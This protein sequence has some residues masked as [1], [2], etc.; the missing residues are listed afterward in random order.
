MKKIVLLLAL[1]SALG[2]NAQTDGLSYQAIIIDPNVQE[3]PGVNATGNILPNADVTLRFTI[4]DA[5]GGE[6]Y[7]ETQDTRTDKYGMVNL[8]IGQ[9][10]AL[11]GNNFT[12]IFW[13]GTRKDLQ[14]EVKLNG[15]F[16]DL[17]KNKLTFVPYAYHRDIIATGYFAL[18]GPATLGDS[19][20]VEGTT[21]LNNSLSVNNE[22]PTNL[23]GTL[24]VDGQTDLNNTVNI[25]NGSPLNA[26]GALNVVGDSQLDSDLTVDGITN[27][28]NDLN[29]NNNRA[30]VL[31]G[32]LRVDGQTDLNGDVNI[33]NGSGLD[34]S[35]PLNVGG[36]TT[37]GDDLIV[38]GTTNLNN[39]LDVNN[40][41]PSRLTGTLNVE[42]ET[43]LENSLTVEG[44]TSL[45]SSFNVNNQSPSIL[46]GSLTVDLET[47]LNSSLSVNNE[48]PTFL[49]GPLNVD[50]PIGLNNN[51]TVNGITN[52]NGSLFVNN[53]APTNL[54]GSLFVGGPA[55][56]DS[57][58]IVNGET[59]LNQGLTVANASETLLTGELFVDGETFLNNT[60][61][62]LN[63]SPTN[64]TGDLNVDGITTLNNSL[65]VANNTPTL[66]T[67]TIEVEQEAT[68]QDELS[69]L[70]GSSTS[71]TGTLTVDLETTL[72]SSLTV[73]N[74]STTELSG[75]L[76]VAGATTLEDILTVNGATT[77]NNDLTVTGNTFL[78]SLNTQT[79]N[80]ESDNANFIASF[81]NTNT[82]TGDGIVIR[83]GKNHGAFNGS[84]I[85]NYPNP[86]ASE[87]S[88]PL[89]ILKA[90]LEN[91]TSNPSFTSSE[92]FSL[93]PAA[94]RVGSL[95]NLNNL[96]FSEINTRSISGTS[97]GLTLPIAFPNLT[98]PGQTL[99]NGYTVFGGTNIPFVNI[100]IPAWEIP[101]IP[102]PNIP[103]PIPPGTIPNP[104]QY[105]PALPINL[106]VTGLPLVAMPVDILVNYLPA[107]AGDV[108]PDSLTKENEYITFQDKD[109]RKTGTIRAQ[110]LWDFKENTVLDNIYMLNLLSDFVGID[111]VDGITA[112]TVGI[113][114]FIDEFNKI[115][116]EYSSGN[117]DYAEWLE[118]EDVSEYITAG[119]I[120]AVKGGKITRNLE[121][122]EQVMVVSHRPIILGNAPEENKKELGNNIAFMGQVPV[123]VLGPVNTGDYIVAETSIKG[124]GKAIA[125][126]D[127]TAS[128][129]KYTVGRSWE[130]NL[131]D[132]P[133]LV[134]TVVGVHN[135]DW[136]SIIQKL[137]EKQ[138]Q[139]EVKFKEIEA[140]VI[141]LDKKTDELIF[142]NK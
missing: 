135:G 58:L 59:T 104:A 61:N 15:Q 123:K 118:R 131:K 8:I 22:S 53:N 120:I 87:L 48:S 79:I 13:D 45:E 40:N 19:L 51:L 11:S 55:N 85:Y 47:N 130:K 121:N 132:G 60:L 52:L 122:A 30:T 62:V 43:V 125:P 12:D 69:V 66:L 92:V 44:A 2:I 88:G 7:K 24:T 38:E 36:L 71:L 82:A 50:G 138:Q 10:D 137:K 56:M 127:M 54:T 86:V 57:T 105:I 101:T 75:I 113:T 115:G 93:A 64:L 29:V 110:S 126:N 80:I 107:T 31:T 39:S 46:S 14:V 109:G 70:N 34:I 119:D 23:T 124:Y 27:L 41:S 1:F 117:G 3:L 20:V 78:S 95:T 37:L 72:N 74:G 76:N 129:F 103:I 35:G 139:Y 106:P 140:Q 116:V 90:R 91:P 97:G 133:K 9:G 6:E 28:N 108:S 32:T 84:T 16:A 65:E 111:L 25:N 94:M 42:G 89:N 21:D 83:L 18:D 4:L 73:A 142:E 100:S 81:I 26:S 136:I 17:G 63:A 112:G 67:G 98:V 5:S 141:E 102:L 99:L 134:N 114:N 77:I 49:S 68:F 128:D 96:I 33:N